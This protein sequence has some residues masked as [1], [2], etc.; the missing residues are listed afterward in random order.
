ML[1]QVIE[2]QG[3]YL[4][5]GAFGTYYAA[6]YEDDS[7]CELAN[8]KY[9]GRVTAIHQ[10][11]AAAGCNALKTNTFSANLQCLDG[12]EEELH[13]IVTQ[14]YRLAKTVADR[15]HIDVFADIGPIAEQKDLSLFV[16]Y[17]KI[18]DM[19]LAQ[20]AKKFLFETFYNADEIISICAY[21]KE[22]CPDSTIIVSFA[23][24]ADGYTRQGISGE[25]LLDELDAC[26]DID[27]LGMNCIC[28]PMHLD[29]LLQRLTPKHHRL[30][31]MPNS[32]YPTILHNRTYFRDNRI[33]YAEE[34]KQI[35]A[36]GATIIGGCCGTT[37]EY[38]KAIK[39]AL[40]QT[41]HCVHQS[42][43]DDLE[44]PSAKTDQDAFHQKI[45]RGEK[46]IAVEFDPPNHCD[47]TK[48]MK[49]AQFLSEAG[50]DAIT[51]ADCPIARAR[52]D[53]SLL[54]SKLHREMGLN[55]IPH[56]TCRDRNINATKALL[57]GLAIEGVHN[58]L[59]VTGDPIPAEDRKQIK[60]VFNFNSQILAGFIHDLN[61]TTFDQPFLICGA[62]NINA[63]NFHAELEKA[64][65]KETQ[66][67]AAFMTQPVLSKRALENL[68]QA[69]QTLQGKLFGGI[70]P[71]VSH[72]NAIYMNN[73]IS[74]IDVDEDIIALYEGQDREQ[75]SALAVNISCAIADELYDI[76]DGYYLITPFNR[77]EIIEQIVTHIHLK[78]SIK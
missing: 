48:F 43:S 74:G 24:S 56:M 37:P 76:V 20:G 33:Y 44:Q 52:V 45:K 36:H 31:I 61:Q 32:G 54:A 27:A 8:I 4:F 59:V 28:G 13:Q 19:F 38:I 10:Q 9:P 6:L 72:R 55:V 41:E 2:Q 62:L 30:S 64:R 70:I 69:R 63:V 21:I 1:E 25:K 67:V 14:G 40:R 77:V 65:H 68:K 18:V 3:Y 35:V 34:M 17:Q 60:G 50:I 49:N 39:T 75:A 47:I 7:P 78:M 11:Y 57:Y 46:I 29:H 66:G 15:Y 73:E 16:Q 42:S 26:Q 22:N 23:L 71:I 5:D 12:G 53:S 58:V 51:I